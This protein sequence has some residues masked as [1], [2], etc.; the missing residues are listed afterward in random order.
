M[1]APQLYINSSKRFHKRFGQLP[2]LKHFLK[3]STHQREWNQLHKNQN[4]KLL[5]IIIH[6][7]N[8]FQKL[9]PLYAR[10]TNQKNM[11]T[12]AW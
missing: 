4:K 10:E 3:G 9:C 7:K 8:T 2:A 1:T 5:R 12:A 6:E 11:T